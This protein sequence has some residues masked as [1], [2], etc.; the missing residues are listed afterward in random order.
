MYNP[1]LKSRFDQSGSY[2]IWVL[3]LLPVLVGSMALAFDAGIAQA[4][5]QRAR[6]AADAAALAGAFTVK[7]ER[8]NLASATTSVVTAAKAR[9]DAAARLGAK[10]NGFEQGVQQ[11]VI[12]VEYPPTSS[13][14]APYQN[15]SDY[16]GIRV[17]RPTP[18]SFANFFGIASFPVEATAVGRAGTD[19]AG[20]T[21]PGLYMYGQNNNKTSDLKHGSKYFIHGGGIYLNAIGTAMFG[22]SGSEMEAQWIESKDANPTNSVEY[23]CDAYPRTSPSDHSG[24]QACVQRLSATREPP[25]QYTPGSCTA[26]NTNCCV[27]PTSSTNL[28]TQLKCPCTSPTYTRNLNT[29]V[30]ASP[31]LAAN[32]FCG[33]LTINNTGTATRPLVLQD[34]STS[35]TFIFANST[36]T[37][38]NGN[39][40]INNSYFTTQTV[41]GSEGVTFF[42]LGGEFKM[43]SSFTSTPNTRLRIYFDSLALDYST[44][45][46]TTYQEDNCGL[47]PAIT[48]VVV[49]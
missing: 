18:S 49:Q 35:D 43:D 48:T 9:V 23:F 17:R 8:L 46:I 1:R 19:A 31:V 34:S 14:F 24:N 6:T 32:T 20:N 36:G 47:L 16:I 10:A 21:C 2:V 41:N 15:L 25:A 30:T 12:D 37:T 28:I 3:I 27:A 39:L 5:R 11:V 13:Y 44:L 7:Q 4:D 29:I 38:A 40:T 33:G 42:S 45:D 22:S 26:Q